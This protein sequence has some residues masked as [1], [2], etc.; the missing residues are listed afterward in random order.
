MCSF[1]LLDHPSDIGIEAKGS[2]LCE[3]FSSAALGLTSL[4]VDPETIRSSGSREIDIEADD[5]EMLLI[6]WLNELIFLF[7]A[8]NFI[9][10]DITTLTIE[11]NRLKA[12]IRGESFSADRHA[13]RVDVKAVTF[14]QLYIGEQ[15]G[16]WTIRVFVDL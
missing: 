5:D 14:H 13:P 3:A 8:R 6:K 7:D 10:K 11:N 12:K 2:T 4:I 16:V 1:A 9:M 15:N